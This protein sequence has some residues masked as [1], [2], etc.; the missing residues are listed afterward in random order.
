MSKKEKKTWKNDN[1]QELGPAQSSDLSDKAQPPD[2][3]N[4]ADPPNRAELANITA[5]QSKIAKI[6]G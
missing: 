6:K 3:M 2:D 1:E 5:S 4:K